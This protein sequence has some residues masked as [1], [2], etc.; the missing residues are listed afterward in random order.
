M[1][2]FVSDKKKIAK[3]TM[4]L[5]IRMVLVMLI[6]LYISRVILQTLGASDFGVYNV[7]G[8]VVVLMS[9]IN[10][11]LHSATVRFLTYELGRQDIKKLSDTFAASLNLH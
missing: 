9:F 11:P 1:A 3:N 5:Y 2:E 6:S 10:G 4:F 7:V 8:G